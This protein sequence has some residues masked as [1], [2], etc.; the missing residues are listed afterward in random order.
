MQILGLLLRLIVVGIPLGF[1]M[2]PKLYCLEVGAIAL[3]LAPFWF[4]FISVRPNLK[5]FESSQNDALQGEAALN[6]GYD[7]LADAI[8]GAIFSTP[9]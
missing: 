1:V 8:Q 3:E 4:L 5:M 6:T 9:R 2:F 7:M